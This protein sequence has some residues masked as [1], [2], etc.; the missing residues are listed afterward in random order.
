MAVP[1]IVGAIVPLPMTVPD[2]AAAALTPL[3]GEAPLVRV[4]RTMLGVLAEPAAV[5]VAT[6]TPLLDDVR[7]SLAAQGLS[8]AVT[9]AA[10]PGSRAQCLTAGLEYF[11]REEISPQLV[12]VHDVR[13]P[14]ASAGLFGRVI[15]ALRNGSTVV[16]PALPL[17]D[18]VKSVDAHGSVTATLDRS[19]LQAVQYPRGFATDQLA[20]LLT[21]R[22]SDEFD[23]LE[24]V[25]AAGAPITVVDGDS[26]AFV[27]ELPRDAAFVEA[28]IAH[29]GDS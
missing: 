9:A 17:T 8:A 25:I 13:R 19:V 3:A 28:I 14:L 15:S 2:N 7:E 21:K 10:D 29:A 23:E 22:S 5:V 24:E 26:S 11:E 16:M 6:A 18:S 20:R 27:V 4:L 12:I 1:S